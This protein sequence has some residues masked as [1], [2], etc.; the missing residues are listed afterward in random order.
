MARE[1]KIRRVKAKDDTTSKK[2][3]MSKY[4]AKV[5]GVETKKKKRKIPKWLKFILKVLKPVG[6]VFSIILI[7]FRPIIKY[8]KESWDELKLVRWPNRC[9]TWKMT[10][11][12]LAFSVV[13]SAMVLLLDAL[14]N[15]VFTT[16]LS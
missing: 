2:P 12:V 1:T 9:E 11:A 5:A 6:K 7:P 15:W 14:F 8:F 13:F 4:A 3:K 16:L 10:G